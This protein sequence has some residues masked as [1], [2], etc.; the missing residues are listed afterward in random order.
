L[1]GEGVAAQST[2]P[3]VPGVIVQQDGGS[4]VPHHGY[5]EEERPVGNDNV[6]AEDD[7]NDSFP[8]PDSVFPRLRVP[9]AW[10]NFKE[11]I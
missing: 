2:V 7:L 9:E 11:S 10:S 5:P 8:Q 4:D 6:D 3:V 1:I